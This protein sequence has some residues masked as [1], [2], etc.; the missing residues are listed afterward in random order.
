M[1]DTKWSRCL[2]IIREHNALEKVRVRLKL[3]TAAT[4][5]DWGSFILPTEGRL[6]FF[7]QIGPVLSPDVDHLRM[8]ERRVPANLLGERRSLS[9]SITKYG[10]SLSPTATTLKMFGC[11]GR[12]RLCLALKPRAHF[13]VAHESRSE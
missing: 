11:Q 5:C 9:R 4:V 2:S 7:P 1:N 6:E 8:I 12:Q 13:L 10:V 3:P